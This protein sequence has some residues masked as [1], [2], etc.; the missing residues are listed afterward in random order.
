MTERNHQGIRSTYIVTGLNTTLGGRWVC[1]IL[2]Y[3]AG[4]MGCYVSNSVISI[5]S[6]PDSQ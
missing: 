3:A 1:L 6:Q 5:T 4:G 2:N